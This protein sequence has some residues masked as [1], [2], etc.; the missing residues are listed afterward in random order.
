MVLRNDPVLHRF[1]YIFDGIATLHGQ[2]CPRASVLVRLISGDNTAAK[3]TV[4]NAD[5]S[6]SLEM[7]IDAENR[8]PVDWIMEAY[9]PDFQKVE[10]SG[11]RI[12]QREE[13]QEK[14]QQPIVVTTPSNSSSLSLSKASLVRL[15]GLKTFVLDTNV[16]IHDPEALFTFEGSQVVLP[17]TVVEELD[18]FKRTNDNRGRSARA[19]SRYLDELRRHGKLSEG[20]PL[21]HG[22]Q[23]RVEVTARAAL[24]YQFETH[25]KDNRILETVMGLVKKARRLS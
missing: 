6:Y 20:V 3:G 19:V 8:A 11:R 1:N 24:P 22:G 15:K 25:N 5:G 16:L 9:T 10:L 4:T 7:F 17:L 12:V 23:L 14:Q 2:P 18:G 13:E 21:E